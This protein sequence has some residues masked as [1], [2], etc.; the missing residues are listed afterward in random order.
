[1]LVVMSVRALNMEAGSSV[2]VYKD[3]IDGTVLGGCWIV[4]S[5][6]FIGSIGM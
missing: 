6:V 5:L 1:M 3:A 2:F 4:S